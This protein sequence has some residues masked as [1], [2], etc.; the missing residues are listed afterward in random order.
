[1][2]TIEFVRQVATGLLA[3]SLLL[4]GCATM[5]L[6]SAVDMTVE[7]KADAPGN[8]LVYIDGKYIGTLKAVS[9]RGVR[10]PEG[11]H[12]ITVEKSGYFPYDEVVVSDLKPI[13]LEVELLRLPD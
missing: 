10:I 12:R 2:R 5:G 7:A 9:V 3:T 1:M 4:S 8:A 6:R 11:E 13:H